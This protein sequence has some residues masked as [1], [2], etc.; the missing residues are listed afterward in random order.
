[1]GVQ[2]PADV[3][4]RSHQVRHLEGRADAA[5]ELSLVLDV[6]DVAKESD[7]AESRVWGQRAASSSASGRIFKSL[8]VDPDGVP[9]SDSPDTLRLALYHREH[10][11]IRDR[12]ASRIST[13][14]V[15]TSNGDRADAR[16]GSLLAAGATSRIDVIEASLKSEACRRVAAIWFL[17]G[18]RRDGLR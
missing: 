4:L 5:G 11:A 18:E 1:M 9:S 7:Y 14:F 13:G 2:A 12:H 6:I 17:P 3:Q 16:R 15:L 10:V 8:G